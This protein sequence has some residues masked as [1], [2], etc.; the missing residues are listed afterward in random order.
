MEGRGAG[1][2]STQS[3][4]ICFNTGHYGYEE[5]FTDPSYY[6]QILVMTTPH[7]GNYG[8]SSYE[9]ESDKLQVRGMVCN[10]LSTFYWRNIDNVKGVDEWFESEGLPIVTDIDTRMLVKKLRSVGTQNCVI[11]T[12]DKSIEELKSILAET[13]RMEGLEL[14]SRVS[15]PVDYVDGDPAG[16]FLVVVIDYGAKKSI[17][18]NLGKR[19][20]RVY[21]VN[22]F[23]PAKEI[24]DMC[25]DGVV[26]SNGPGDPAAMPYAISTAREIIEAGIPLLGICLG[27][28]ITG[29]ALGASTY[30]LKFGHRG[31][32]H[33]VYDTIKK[34]SF[35]TSQNH[36]FAISTESLKKVPGV[37]I[38]FVHLNDDTLM[39]FQLREKPVLCVQFHPEAGPGPHDTTFIFDEF[40]QMM[41]H[42][43]EKVKGRM[44]GVLS[45]ALN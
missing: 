11:S 37:I 29:L 1:A 36:G 16:D 15:T 42:Y 2:P 32:N 27:H 43:R 28:Q 25:P 45:P 14:A 20:A 44:E 6:G 5:I 34:K 3:G 9:R 7:I 22:C 18:R 40:F 23:K 19:G 41:S 38:R 17:I 24:I 21:V 31:I 8:V 33:P 12:E 26:L 4:E 39:G 30:K 35:I 10:K 13:A